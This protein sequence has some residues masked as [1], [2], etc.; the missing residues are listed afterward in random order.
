MSLAGNF[1]YVTA[2]YSN[3]LTVVDISTPTSPHI[4]GTLQDATNLAF[5]NDVAVQGN[6]AYVANQTSP[7][8]S[9][10][11]VD[12]SNPASPH[13]AATLSDPALAYA[14][15]LRVRGSFAYVAAARAAAIDMVDVSN[16][17][18]PK[19]VGSVQDSAHLNHTTGVDFAL[20][21]RYIVSSSPLLSSESQT[22]YPA[23]PLQPGGP[24]NTGTVSVL[25]V[26]PNPVAV[27]ITA[28]MAV[29]Y[30]QGQKVLAA[31]TCT[32]GGLFPLTA[33]Q[34]PAASGAAIDT[35]SPG[36]HTFTVTGTDQAGRTG[37]ATVTY[38]VQGPP[39]RV[40]HVH[41]KS[42]R[43]REHGKRARH[44][45]PIGT[46]FTFT[47][48]EK[49]SV[50]L[51]FARHLPGR[52]SGRRCVAPTRHNRHHRGCVRL[53][54]AVTLTLSGRAG[55]NR[56]AFRGKIRGHYLK[57]GTYTLT[58]TATANGQ[59]VKRTL[60]FTIVG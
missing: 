21:G 22:Q 59:T 34:G 60:T 24:T 41:Q 47:L 36:K 32:A 3:T 39:P 42:R 40:S 13:V 30:K 1:A 17:L 37:S 33:C 27:R 14:Y 43:W 26:D 35:S 58:I 57:P 45:P 15:F 52:R 12:V 10:A 4:A 48:S 50:K 56:L 51:S 53:A 6:Y 55:R 54:R 46:V 8:G 20:T 28:P 25:D 7:S 5:P 38:S 18:A 29:T 23:Y 9:L 11:V 19:L 31:Y 2:S 44:R 16:P 49:A